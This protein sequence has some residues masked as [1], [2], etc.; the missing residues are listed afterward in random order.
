MYVTAKRY[1]SEYG[2]NG[3]QEKIA[4][5]QKHFPEM[6]GLGCV[7]QV[8]VESMYWRKANAI[9]RWFVDN[10]QDGKDNCQESYLDSKDLYALQ[11]A[12]VAV[13]KDPSQAETLLPAR[14]GFFF[15]GIDYDEGY[16]DDVRRT[17]DWLNKVL[18][19]GALDDKLKQWSFYYQASW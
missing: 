11:S 8:E 16:M 13:L 14:N 17:L 4:A 1:L 6:A 2:D 7:Q 15:G 5:I 12:C 9:H 19:K 18:V 3:D 10:V